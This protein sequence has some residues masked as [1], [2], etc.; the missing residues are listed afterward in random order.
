MN[1]IVCD[2]I[3]TRRLLRFIYEGYERVVEPHAYGVNT[4]GREAVS[5][6]LAGGWSASATEPGWR[7]YLVDQMRDVAALAEGF[8]GART[9]YNPNDTH[10]VRV[11]CQIEEA[12]AS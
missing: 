6:W 8:D 9:G 7:M 5:A 3:R 12:A 4:A 2:A 10:Y 1:T 11:Y